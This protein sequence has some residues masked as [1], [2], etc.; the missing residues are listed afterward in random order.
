MSSFDFPYFWL[1]YVDLSSNF[2]PTHFINI[3]IVIG[4]LFPTGGTG[5]YRKFVAFYKCFPFHVVQSFQ[6]YQYGNWN[7]QTKIS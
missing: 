1:W 5:Q 2:C 3:L 6:W 4:V 7:M